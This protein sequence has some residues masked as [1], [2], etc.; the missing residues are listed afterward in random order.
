MKRLESLMTAEP[1]EEELRAAYEEQTDLFT[2]MG[3][4]NM[5]VLLL[6]EGES[7]DVVDSLREAVLGGESFDE[8]VARLGLGDQTYPRSFDEN[9][10]RDPDVTE[11]DGVADA[12]SSL[13]VGA[14]CDPID[15]HGEGFIVL[16][17]E[18]RDGAG[19]RPFEECREEL[20]AILSEEDFDSAFEAVVAEAEIVI[21]GDIENLS[22]SGE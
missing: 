7:T 15:N 19:R 8:A 14:F 1:T 10:F 22:G 6:P 3:T 12:I 21:T 5:R 2:V 16:Y 13:P 20:A 18:S 11:F 9:S 17:C 4:V